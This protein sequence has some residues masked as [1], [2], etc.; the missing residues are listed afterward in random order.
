M[1]TGRA[2]GEEVAS[3]SGEDHGLPARVT[4]ER[5]ALGHVLDRHAFPEVRPRKL[6]LLVPHLQSLR[7]YRAIWGFT[8]AEPTA[9][10]AIFDVAP[11][12]TVT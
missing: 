11:M 7:S 10:P 4:E 5:K 8:D 12:R 9:A 2:H 3:A 6:A 1:R